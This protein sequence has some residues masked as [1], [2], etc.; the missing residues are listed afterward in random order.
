MNGV[1]QLR[2]DPAFLLDWARRIV[3]LA[4]QGVKVNP[5]DL[6]RA[7]AVVRQSQESA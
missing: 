3:R 1:R 6:K 2:H 4:E 7:R 5:D